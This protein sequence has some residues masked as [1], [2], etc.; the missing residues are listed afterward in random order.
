MCTPLRAAGCALN[1]ATG[2]WVFSLNTAPKPSNE[3]PAE[4]RRESPGAAARALVLVLVTIGCL[5]RGLADG[6]QILACPACEE[7][8]WPCRMVRA[9]AGS[10]FLGAYAALA[11]FLFALRR[12]V[13]G[14]PCPRATALFSLLVAVWAALV[15][16]MAGRAA[17]ATDVTIAQ[18]CGT[19]VLVVYAISC[20]VV[21]A[22]LAK[23]RADLLRALGDS[24]RQGRA[25]APPA[26]LSLLD[27]AVALSAGVCLAQGVRY[28]LWAREMNAL[29][30][31][32]ACAADL[33]AN[34]LLELAPCLVGALLLRPRGEASPPRGE[35]ARLRAQSPLRPPRSA[36][37][38]AAAA[39]AR[40]IRVQSAPPPST[41]LK[42]YDATV[43]RTPTA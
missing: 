19:A 33:L 29:P 26:L 28:A 5:G 32:A 3:Q 42:T 11:V 13:D 15:V 43:A 30:C 37:E 39:A 12:G 4:E 2:A 24:P 9:L 34:V 35:R 10:G 1:L 6:A 36:G 25:K 14:L 7:V 40:A 38:A 17:T 16:T 41:E 22:A 27:R 18:A 31:D 20:A 21:A 8:D 23:T